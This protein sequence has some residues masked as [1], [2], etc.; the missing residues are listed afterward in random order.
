MTRNDPHA[1]PA[2]AAPQTASPIEKLDDAAARIREEPT[3]RAGRVRLAG[4]GWLDLTGHPDDVRAVSQRLL[5][6]PYLGSEVRD[7]RP[8]EII[9]RFALADNHHAFAHM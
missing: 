3:V 4:D 9:V 5:T 1:A 7:E 8:G 6:A 2:D